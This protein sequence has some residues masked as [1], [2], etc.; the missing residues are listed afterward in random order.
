MGKRQIT[1]YLDVEL[2]KLLSKKA[3]DEECSRSELIAKIIKEYLK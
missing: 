1:I 2:W 3:I